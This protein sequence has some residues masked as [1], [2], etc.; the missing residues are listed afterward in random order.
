MLLV[1]QE[2]GKALQ[3]KVVPTFFI[4]DGTS[5]VGGRASSCTLPMFSSSHA[6]FFLFFL[7][8]VVHPIPPYA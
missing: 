7:L 1:L 3:V 8:A 5:L 6:Q 4:F 2:L